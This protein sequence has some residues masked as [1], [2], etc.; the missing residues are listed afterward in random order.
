MRTMNIYYT[1]ITKK[2]NRQTFS[3]LSTLVTNFKRISR[4]FRG[5]EIPIFRESMPPEPLVSSRLRIRL[6]VP[7]SKRLRLRGFYFNPQNIE[8]TMTA[9]RFLEKKGQAKHL[10]TGFVRCLSLFQPLHHC[11]IFCVVQSRGQ[12]YSSILQFISK[13]SLF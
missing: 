4:H 11:I 2:K 13:K 8:V 3:D 1:V 5:I 6:L 10:A 12:A 9:V 7:D